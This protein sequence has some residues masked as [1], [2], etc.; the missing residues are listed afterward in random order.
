MEASSEQPPGP[1][2]S[3]GARSRPRYPQPRPSHMAVL[4]LEGPMSAPFTSRRGLDEGGEPGPQD[5]S[6]GP[7]QEPPLGPARVGASHCQPSVSGEAGKS[8][9]TTGSG[10][11][12]WRTQNSTVYMSPSSTATPSSSP[13]A[14]RGH[15]ASPVS[16]AKPSVGKQREKR[17][18]PPRRE[19]RAWPRKHA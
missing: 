10:Q 7:E 1:G 17:S 11:R 9:T 15:Q 19:R 3:G 2:A 12:P 5:A 4:G 18:L 16:T 13:C 14:S 8:G 6:L